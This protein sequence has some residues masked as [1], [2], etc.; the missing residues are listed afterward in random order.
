M[1][2]CPVGLLAL[3]GDFAKHQRAFA[4]LGAPTVLVRRPS[5]LAQCA[6]LV[7]PGGESTTL[8]RLLEKSGLRPAV[9]DFARR[10]PVMGTCAGLVL[11]AR[12]LAPESGADHG[13]VPLGLLDCR[14]QRN[15][16][17]RQID[18][19]SED[20]SVV[21]LNGS[22]EPF[23]G[24]FI[25][26]PRIL[27]VGDGVQVLARLKGEPVAIGQNRILGLTF[28]PEL[29]DDSR[30]HAYFLKLAADPSVKIS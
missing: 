9:Q 22:P 1:L 15:A 30:F 3:Q 13:V 26:A 25:R 7:I 8:A 29:T 19:F 27:E 24:V 2:S 17:G 23:R 16:Y 6:A 11:L 12:Q 14:V 20:V 18:S 4:A 10:L 21:K 28:H 5:E